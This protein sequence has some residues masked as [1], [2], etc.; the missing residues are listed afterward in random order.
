MK[1]KNSVHLNICHGNSG[2]IFVIETVGLRRSACGERSCSVENTSS[3]AIPRKRF[4]NYQIKIMR[5]VH[6]QNT[7]GSNTAMFS[8]LAL[9][10]I[11]Q[12]KMSH[13]LPAGTE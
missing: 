8:Y 11:K 12:G 3:S 6:L 13:I 2:G 4:L 7:S 1:L 9:S 5:V 10:I